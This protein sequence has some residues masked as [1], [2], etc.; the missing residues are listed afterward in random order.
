MSKIGK[1]ELMIPAGVTVTVSGNKV[2]VKGKGGELSKTFDERLVSVNIADGKVTVS[3]KGADKKAT[4]LWGT[5]AAHIK[6]MIAGVE[7]PFEKKL[8]IEGVGYKWDLKGKEI[9]LALGFSHPVNV[10]IPEGL[11]VKID[12][13]NMDISGI[14]KELVGSFAMRIRK[15]KLPEPYKGKGIRYSDEVI[16][17]KQGKRS[18]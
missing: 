16:R 6:N 12:K 18:A 4:Q 10:S 2:T 8:I 3:K 17:R 1:Q 13:G 5:M 11:T 9:V 15:L 14:D 7:K